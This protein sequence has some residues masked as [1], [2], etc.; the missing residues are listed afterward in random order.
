MLE[1]LAN[2]MRMMGHELNDRT[3]GEVTLSISATDEG[4]DVMVIVPK[5]GWGRPL[6][7]LYGVTMQLF[8]PNA[9]S[10]HERYT[11]YANDISVINPSNTDAIFNA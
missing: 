6:V 5:A 3:K 2:A 10:S 9:S 1:R 8:S 4:Y 7:S 11:T